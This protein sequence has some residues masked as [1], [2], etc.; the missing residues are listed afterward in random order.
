MFDQAPSLPPK[1]QQTFSLDVSAF[2]VEWG[3]PVF[4]APDLPS[5][6]NVSAE[7]PFTPVR[8]TEIRRTK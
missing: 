1:P 3:K 6:I 4:R 7:I 5:R 8:V 2:D